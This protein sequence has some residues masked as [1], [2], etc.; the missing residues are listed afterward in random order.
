MITIRRKQASPLKP[1][2]L[3]TSTQLLALNASGEL[4]SGLSVANTFTALQT[5]TGAGFTASGIINSGTEFRLANTFSRVAQMDGLGGWGGGYNFNVN[6]DSSRRDSTGPVAG[7]WFNQN[8]VRMFAEDSA[9]AGV[10]TTRVVVSPTGLSVTGNVVSVPAAST[11]L[12]VNG[13]MTFDRVSNTE[14]RVK[15]RGDDGTTRS[16]TLTLS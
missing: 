3:P 7:L 10:I 6:S 13:Q 1:A 14:L 5:I 16:V 12:T 4:V 8:E 15:L 9:A 2:T 11:T